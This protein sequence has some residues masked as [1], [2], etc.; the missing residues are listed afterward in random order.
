M[1]NSPSRIKEKLFYGWVVVIASFI[2]F[3]VVFG[4]RLSF[5]V[6][7]KSLASEFGLTRAQTSGLYSAQW[8]VGCVLAIVGG[9]GADKFSPR[10]L[11]GLMGSFLGLSLILTSQTHSLW[12]LFLVYGFLFAIGSG[13]IFGVVTSTVVRWFTRQRGFAIGLTTSGVGLGAV[14]MAPF[15]TYLIENLGW[16]KSYIVIGIIAWLLILPMAC[17]LRKDPSEMGLLPDGAKS[18]RGPIERS[19]L[20]VGSNNLPGY[21][22]LRAFKTRNFWCLLFSWLLFSSCVYMV[23]THI[24][25]HVTDM[26][27]P[28]MKAATIVSL[29]GV[30][31]ILGRLL[32][33]R[34]SD[35]IGRKMTVLACALCL[36]GTILW[37]IFSKDLWMFYFFAVAF[38]FF[39]GGLDATT[40]S[41][42]GDLFGLTSIGIV[43]G[44]LSAGWSLGAAIG[45][46]LGGLIYDI[47]SNYS[48]AF[49]INVAAMIVVTLL[50]LLT[51]RE[52]EVDK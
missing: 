30:M 17:L 31:N 40:T 46:F 39:Y 28:A 50:L 2:I 25:P 9:W 18:N 38:G 11:V 44:T 6:F 5:G 23:F 47:H 51:K 1:I 14:I 48:I 7:F 49:T 34:I 21:S 32:V 35:R 37:L 15:A 22:L 13:G 27:I 43:M 4:A 24:V 19:D 41:L 8:L 42:V 45:P 10:I 52:R 16:R 26:E 3:L 20:V 29:I 36:A 33:G 12:Q